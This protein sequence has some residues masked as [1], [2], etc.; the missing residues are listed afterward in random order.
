MDVGVSISRMV[1]NEFDFEQMEKRFGYGIIPTIVF[2]THAMDKALA[3]E[4]L[5]TAAQA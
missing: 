1:M 3:L 4:L 5:T 2:L